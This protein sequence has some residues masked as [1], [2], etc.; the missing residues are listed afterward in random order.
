[1]I[2]HTFYLR[3]KEMEDVS[4][5][6][7]IE[8]ETVFHECNLA[9]LE[10]QQDQHD[11]DPNNYEDSIQWCNQPY[12]SKK[13]MTKP[14]HLSINH[15]I[16]ALKHEKHENIKQHVVDECLDSMSYDELNGKHTS[17]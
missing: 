15:T 3:K 8:E 7:P 1:M 4:Y 6:N 16:S 9:Q 12:C 17:F 10:L 11:T 2:A 14:F 13:M 5:P